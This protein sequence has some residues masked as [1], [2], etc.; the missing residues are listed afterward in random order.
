M[1]CKALSI[2]IKDFDEPQGIVTAY[3]N[4]YNNEDSDGDI[5]MPGCF[6]KTVSENFKRLRVLKDHNSRESL[7]IPKSVDANDP[8]GLL[9]VTQFNMKKDLSRDMYSDIVLAKSNGQNAE[10]SIGYG[11]VKRDTKDNRKITEYGWLGEYSFLSFYAANELALVTDV[12]GM[13]D[14]QKSVKAIEL[15]TKMYNLPHSD[16]R[17]IAV[18]NILKSLT[19][20][21][22]Q[23]GTTDVEPIDFFKGL[24]IDKQKSIFTFNIN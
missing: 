22:S 12:K 10:L 15:L 6:S 18:E 24:E 16:Q 3:A 19:K 11:S 14:E 13:S 8:Y 17:L 1:E 9:T 21:P 2:D 4:V 23:S 5:S 20:E 7:G